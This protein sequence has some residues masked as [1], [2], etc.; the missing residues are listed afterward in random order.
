MPKKVHI[1]YEHGADLRPFGSASIRLL[2]PFTHPSL[3]QQVQ[4]TTGTAYAGQQVDLLIVDRLWQPGVTLQAVERLRELTDRV[5]AKLVY[6]LDDNFLDLPIEAAAHMSEAQAS[7]HAFLLRQ[8]DCLWVTSLPLKERLSEYNNRIRVI[9]P[10]LDERLIVPRLP[11]ASRASRPSLPYTIGYMGTFTHDQDLEAVVPALRQVCARHPGQIEIQIIG[12]IAESAAHE[13]LA[14]LP[15]RL[16]RTEP[17]EEEYPLFML[18]L[19]GRV[20][21]D[22]AIAPLQENA[23]NRCKSDLKLLDYSAI[24]CPAIFS[25]V[26]AYRGSIEHMH[27][28]LLVPNQ[29]EQWVSAIETLLENESLRRR[30]AG[31]V[32]RELHTAR[33]LASANSSWLEALEFAL[34]PS[35]LPS[36]PPVTIVIPTKNAEAFLAAQL[37]AIFN[38][39]TAF[40]FDVILIDSGSKDRTLEIAAA[41]PVNLL[42]I[43]PQEFN[44]GL[45]RN[46]GARQ[47]RPESEFIVFLSQDACPENPNWLAYLIQPMIADRAI[48]GVFSRHVPRPEASASYVRQLTSL[49][50]SGGT[51]RLYKRLPANPAEFQAQRFFLNFFSN[52]SSAI[53]RS[54]W[55]QLPFEPVEFAE[56][57]LWADTVVQSGHVI[58]FEP[59][60]VVLHSH[61]FNPVEQFRQS[62]DHARGFDLLFSPPAFHSSRIW[63]NQFLGIPLQIYKDCRFVINDSFF[64]SRSLCYKLYM[65]L[66]S[67]PWQFAT[68]TGAWV[69]AN[70]RSMPEWLKR[71]ASR[72]ARIKTE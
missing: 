13:K 27:N 7:A 26:P 43:P 8:A 51:E 71:W 52:T 10:V 65:M 22:L 24:A 30:I 64:A 29:T 41:H 42:S 60:S 48:A 62:V 21:W 46:L 34:Q 1:L 20:Q 14:G 4:V 47:A 36:N 45:T 57:A 39:E 38:Q 37:E 49:T 25:D 6:A 2:Q 58:L 15:I 53:R 69:G 28:G 18:W 40:D 33:T 61:D 9:P 67:V 35:V 16:I 56:D 70:F 72:Q 19:T 17:G 55:E 11:G 50:Q 54:V 59:A 5:G 66:F 12:G 23:F 44:H 68:I 3:A 32:Y 31:R 63:L